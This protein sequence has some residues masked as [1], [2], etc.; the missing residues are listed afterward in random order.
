IRERFAEDV[1]D[2]TLSGDL[3]IDFDEDVPI[4]IEIN[5]ENHAVTI[6]GCFKK[7]LKSSEVTHRC[8]ELKDASSVD[9]SDF[10]IGEDAFLDEYW[11][12]GEGEHSE[13]YFH[14]VDIFNTSYKEVAY[15]ASIPNRDDIDGRD[16]SIFEGYFMYEINDDGDGE[17]VTYVGP[18]ATVESRREQDMAVV[19][20]ILTKGDPAALLGEDFQ[21]QYEVWTDITV[22]VGNVTLPNQDYTGIILRPGAK[23]TVKG[24]ITLTGGKL[25]WVVTESDQ[26]DLTGLTLIKKHPSPD[27]VKIR[28]DKKAGLNTDLLSAKAGKGKISYVLGENSFDI[29]IW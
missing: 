26:L 4:D 3:V 21:G 24:T 27:M 23:L 22:D 14:I 25:D 5:C 6:K 16:F 8:I 28:Y 1:V 17:C 9:M 19:T 12:P 11:L 29:S 2:F 20:E 18:R 13:C 7:Q 15:P 10:S